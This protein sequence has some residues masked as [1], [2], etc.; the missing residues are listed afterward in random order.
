MLM[1][2]G[3]RPVQAKAFCRGFEEPY[4]LQIVAKFEDFLFSEE[5]QLLI[6]Y[7]GSFLERQDHQ[8]LSKKSP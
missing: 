2:V 8:G 6:V 3:L 7:F 4:S 1:I 5:F